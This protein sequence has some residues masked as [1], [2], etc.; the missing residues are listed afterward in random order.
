MD[1]VQMKETGNAH[2]PAFVCSAIVGVVFGDV[3]IDAT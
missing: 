1:D 2:L 3:G